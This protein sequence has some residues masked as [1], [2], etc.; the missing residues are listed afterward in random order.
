MKFPH[1]FSRVHDIYTN[2]YDPEGARSFARLYWHTLLVTVFLMLIASMVYG[3][4]ELY[5]VLHQLGEVPQT[6][7][8]SPVLDRTA[9]NATISGFDARQ[10]TFE[11]LRAHPT[12][13]VSDPSR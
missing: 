9:L 12:L 1:V 3:E 8:P 11:S 4:W 5:E 7:L 2:R 10:Q 13:Q 6:T